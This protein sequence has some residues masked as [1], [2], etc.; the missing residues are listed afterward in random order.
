ML[1]LILIPLIFYASAVMLFTLIQRPMFTAYNRKSNKGNIRFNDIL[2]I[3][4]YGVKTD[5]IVASYLTAI[6]LLL[7]CAQAFIPAAFLKT[8]LMAYIIIISLIISLIMLADTLLYEF[9]QYK[10]DSSVLAY[11]RSLKGSFA[12]VST[13]YIIIALLTEF[14]FWIFTTAW[15]YFPIN[16]VGLES[17]FIAH[18]TIQYIYA[19]MTFL[20]L[21]TSCFLII[22]GVGRRPHNPSISFFSNNLFFNHCALNPNYSFIYSLSVN[23]KIEG[24]FRFFPENECKKMIENIY[25]RNSA[26]RLKL[27]NTDRPNILF[28]IWESLCARFIEPL[29]GEKDVTPCFNHLAEEGIF[30]T[31]V[32]SSGTRTDK[33]IVA[34]L[35]GYPAQPTTSVIRMTKK[36]PNLPALPAIF[37]DLGYQTSI[38]HG[39]D[40]TIFHKSDYYLTIGHDHAITE[41]DFP[42]NSPRG[43]WGIHD[44]LIMDWLYDDIIRKTETG[45][46][47]FTTFQTLSSHETWIV[48]YDRLLPDKPVEN[49]FAY[50]DAAFGDFIDRLKKSPAWDNLLIVVSGDHGCNMCEPIERSR[51]SHIPMLLL[52]GAVKQPLRFDSIMSQTDLAATLLGQL[53]LPSDNFIFSRDVFAD[54]YRYPCSF[55]AFNN[56][57]MFRD[58]SGFTV[59]DNISG[60]ATEN[61]DEARENKGKAILQHLY[62][63]LAKR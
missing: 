35:S 62:E 6:P 55:H 9:W 54:S 38:L 58:D 13:G 63:D 1:K 14:L 33:G 28:I 56:G 7:C 10:I 18:N 36:L 29:G 43:K 27:L 25:P 20:V 5:F 15:L 47:W 17:P 8:A 45:V 26:P 57:F 16:F 60:A 44:G 40:L 24:A 32:D 53:G 22:R 41:N 37:R 52:G 49:S 3:F 4:K 46:K 11:L 19:G 51:Y 39:G 42:K 31:H 34:L 23:D 50:V 12:S 21:G 48:P 59:V 61:P 30:F 2:H